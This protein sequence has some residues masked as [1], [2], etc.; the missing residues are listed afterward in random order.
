MAMDHSYNS[1]KPERRA[2]SSLEASLHPGGIVGSSRALLETLAKIAAVAKTPATVLITGESGVGKELI[3]Q[4]LHRQSTRADHP[5]V[6]VN[7]AS[8]PRE[9]FESEFFGHTK[10]SFTGA[11]RDRVGRFELADGGTLFLD[12]VGEIPHELQAKLLR[13]L[14]EGRFERVG[15]ER[16]RKVDVRVVAATNQNLR[17]AIAAGRFRAD[18]YYRLGV[19]PIEVP[20]LRERRADIDM[21]AA[22]FLDEACKQFERAPLAL[23]THHIKLLRAHSWPG[24]VRELRN[25][26]ERAV[27]L[28]GDEN[29]ALELAMPED[30]SPAGSCLPVSD[31]QPESYVSEA[32]WRRYYRANLIAALNAAQWQVA[33]K[34][35]AAD[36]LGLKPSTLRDR[37]KSLSIRVP[38][39]E[40]L[41]AGA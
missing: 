6:K 27:I 17:R 14:Q 10:G 41:V 36:R 24:N 11:H 21:L 19:F 18:L 20:P 35:G 29:L 5:L 31:S 25:R 1:G 3:T 33:G 38:R 15:D 40:S 4:E 2:Q 22:Y 13:V 39:Q 30:V 12:E 16:T 8:I 34:G 23:T 37:M 28:S 7:C 32:V 26:I 9:L